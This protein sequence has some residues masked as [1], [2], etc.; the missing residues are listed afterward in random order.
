[1]NLDSENQIEDEFSDEGFLKTFSKKIKHY[2]SLFVSS[3]PQKIQAGQ[4][5]DYT[6]H[7]DTKFMEFDLTS[8]DLISDLSTL[9]ANMTC[10]IREKTAEGVIDLNATTKIGCIPGSVVNNAIKN[11][12]VFLF[13]TQISPEKTDRYSLLSY[14]FEYF[15]KA[16]IAPKRINYLNG[17]YFDQSVENFLVTSEGKEINDANLKAEVISQGYHDSGEFFQRSISHPFMDRINS[18]FLF[19]QLNLLLGGV[20]LKIGLEVRGSNESGF[21]LRYDNTTG[22]TLAGRNFLFIVDKFYL[23]VLRLRPQ[24]RIKPKLHRLLNHKMDYPILNMKP[25]EKTLIR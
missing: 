7:S 19:S 12:R 22:S 21:M 14:I 5:I 13:D 16:N 11:L 2:D 8:P 4:M 18:P 6:S 23:T 1:M 20:Q 25:H 9:T 24:E 3:F 17:S 15:N 10:R